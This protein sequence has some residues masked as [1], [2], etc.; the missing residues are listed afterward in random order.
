MALSVS[1]TPELP[2]PMNAYAQYQQQEGIPVLRGFAV[3]DLH[4]VDLAPWTRRGGRGVF[5]NL[6]GTGGTNDAYVCEIAPG[7]ALAPLSPARVG[8]GGEPQHVA[9]TS[10]G[11][12]AYASAAETGAL[13]AYR[14][15]DADGGQPGDRCERG[16]HGDAETGKKITPIHFRH[17]CPPF[18]KQAG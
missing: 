7:G 11:R 9:L 10:D 6:D 17:L 8:T 5:V 13:Y 2:E 18:G 16:A 12:Y 14:V 4:T 3:D 1:E 15:G